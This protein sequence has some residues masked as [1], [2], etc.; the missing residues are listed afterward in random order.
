VTINSQPLAISNDN[1]PT[2][3]FTTGGAPT[4]TQCRVDAGGLSN[5]VG[6][7]FTPT[8]ADGTH[9]LTII[10]TDGANNSASA[11]TAS[12]IV[13]T[14]APV[15]TF[16]DTPPAQWPVNYFDMRFHATD[17]NVVVAIE[18]SLNGQAFFG[19]TTGQTITTSYNVGSTFAVRA[20]DNAG[21]TSAPIQTSWTSTDGLVLHYPWEQ[22]ATN[23]TSLLAQNPAYS[24]N[25][26][27][28]AAPAIGG[29]AG[30]AIGSV[31][32]GHNYKNTDRILSSSANQGN[33]AASF[34]IRPST[35]SSGTVFSTL[36]ATNG[37]R[38]TQS[39]TLFRVE[40]QDGGQTFTATAS[41]D[42]NR[43]VHIGLRATGPSKGLE[44]WV[45]GAFR[46][47]VP[48]PLRTGFDAG[49]ARDMTVGP[50]SGFDVDDLRFFNR[51]PADPEMCTLLARGSIRNSVCTPL[52][53]GI[54]VDFEHNVVVDTGIWRLNL[55]QP[56]SQTFNKGKT[57]DFM[58]MSSPFTWGISGGLQSQ[59][60]AAHGHSFSFWFTSN[61]QFGRLLDFT[62]Q[63]FVGGP[64]DKCGISVTYVDNQNVA[65]FVGTFGA[66]QTKTVSVLPNK[67]NSI[68]VTERRTVDTTISVSVYVNGALATVIP[69]P[70]GDVFKQTSDGVLFVEKPGTPVD[71]YE[72][73]TED[74]E[75][76]P[77]VL[78]ENGF[79]GEFDPLT[80]SC[81]LTS[82]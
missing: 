69:V 12:F 23:N 4:S 66:Q 60:A 15:V 34:W 11:T 82:N 48:A 7:T 79:D 45:D 32:P 44:I 63:C 61:T 71:E 65:V 47:V 55:V 41:L 5:C 13:D 30:T 37:I 56:Q 25:G 18:C 38:V 59:L 75:A 8:V 40:V 64:P 74:L 35:S 68:V 54:E 78:C 21:N 49:Q 22:G 58:T 33:Y 57:G 53:P 42:P 20:R 81:S 62:Q 3:T 73:W 24:P 51:T 52:S 27:I 36:G 14:T 16:D 43:W 77:E 31:V 28:A 19:C 1:T 10:V 39:D 17:A 67:S 72:F 26:T 76:N 2:V 46:S 70:S 29:W 9:T 50:W 80:G 6:G